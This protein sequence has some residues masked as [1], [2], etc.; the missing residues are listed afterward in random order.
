MKAKKKIKK[1]SNKEMKKVKGG[2]GSGAVSNEGFH[3]EAMGF[4]NAKERDPNAVPI[5]GRK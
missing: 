3:A 4:G 5:I 2:A 1:V